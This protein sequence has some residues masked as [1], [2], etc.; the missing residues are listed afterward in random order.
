MLRLHLP[1]RDG[2]LWS[3]CLSKSQLYHLPRMRR[4]DLSLR[5]RLPP[6]AVHVVVRIHDCQRLCLC[7]DSYP[8]PDQERRREIYPYWQEGGQDLH[9]FHLMALSRPRRNSCLAPFRFFFTVQLDWPLYIYLF[10]FAL[11]ALLK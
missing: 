3:L 8:Y 2:L 7:H 4:K 11:H 9:R 1:N 5:R 6:Q 10:L